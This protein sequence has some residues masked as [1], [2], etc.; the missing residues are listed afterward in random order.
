LKALKVQESINFERNQDPLKS[1]GIGQEFKYKELEREFSKSF[2]KLRVD[3]KKGY[4]TIHSNLASSI[5]T[6]IAEWFKTNPYF[7]IEA[8][9]KKR[10]S[11]GST[12][13]DIYIDEKELRESLNFN[14][15]KDPTKAMDIGNSYLDKEIIKNIKTTLEKAVG[16]MGKS[17]EYLPNKREIHINL[18]DFVYSANAEINYVLADKKN[19]SLKDKIDLIYQ[20]PNNS[21]V[22]ILTIKLL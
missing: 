20:N 13:Y 22:G 12:Y 14:R 6:D 15:E 21:W 8:F 1:M 19:R 7:E 18:N 5:I 3:Y 4:M 2:P 10:T 17:F 16:D 9:E 11:F